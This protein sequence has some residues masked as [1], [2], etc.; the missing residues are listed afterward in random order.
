MRLAGLTLALFLIAPVSPGAEAPK[1]AFKAGQP[2]LFEFDTGPFSGRLKLDGRFQGVYPIV[3]TATGADLTMPPGVFSP[4]RVFSTGKRYGNAARDWPTTPKLRADGAVEVGWAAAKEHPVAIAAVYRW[5]APDTLDFEV[6]VTPEA[7][8]QD[9]ELFMSSYFTKGF[10][11]A[12]YLKPEGQP[13]ANP[14]FVPV[15]PKPGAQGAYVMFPR[16]Q[17]AAAVI[18]DGRWKIPP[19]PV[20]WAVEGWLARPLVLR[21]DAASG[22]TAVMM[23]P[24]ADCFAVSSPWNPATPEGG[25]YRSLY[26]SL[27][28]RD[29]KAGEPAKARCRL[30]VGRGITDQKAVELYESYIRQKE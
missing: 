29:L 28:G 18:R 30:V 17:K 15:D 26:L 4:Y 7:D 16:D 1:T 2:G 5:A 3:D 12:V 25:G 24:A 11:A 8:M 22:V 20:D 23:C 19:S 6:T 10:R 27:F 13:D 21:R 9:F 14:Q